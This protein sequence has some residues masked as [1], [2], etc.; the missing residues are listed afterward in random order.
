[1]AQD[2][3]RH[4]AGHA[5][6]EMWLTTLI[7][8]L[9]CQRGIRVSIGIVCLLLAWDVANTG[10]FVMSYIFCPI[11]FLASLLKNAIQH[12]GWRL[13]LTRIAIPA[14]T[15][16]VVMANDSLQSQIA[17]ANAPKII[18]ACEEFHAA[19]GRFP[20]TLDELVPRYLP[21]VPRAKYCL[22][23][24]DFSYWYLDSH[25]I[26]EWCVIPPYGRRI[27]DFDRRQW[28]YID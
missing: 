4:P 11:W 20:K 17:Q 15:L 23:Y 7:R 12:P 18:A 19:N 8:Y 26:L 13:A 27:Y 16:T 28:N 14:L 9:C 21:S 5:Q 10:S 2:G 24:G 1:M 22:I 6:N 3:N 25:P